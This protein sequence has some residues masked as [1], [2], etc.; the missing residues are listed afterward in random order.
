MY[1]IEVTEQ[2]QGEIGGRGQLTAAEPAERQNRGLLSLDAAVLGRETLGHQ[3]MH[4]MD[5]ALGDISKGYARLLRGHRAG[6]NPRADQKQA[7]LAEQPQPVEKLLIG[8]GVLQ[9]RREPAWQF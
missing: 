6:E 5:D 9:R 8:I 1:G 7:L 4:G 2:H 3:A